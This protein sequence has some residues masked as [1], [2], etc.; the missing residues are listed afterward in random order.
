MS[1]IYC[2]LWC[3]DCKTSK[4]VKYRKSRIIPQ[5]PLSP[6]YMANKKKN[7]RKPGTALRSMYKLKNIGKRGIL[8]K[9]ALEHRCSSRRLISALQQ[10]QNSKYLLKPEW[11]FFS[12]W[13]Q[14]LLV[15]TSDVILMS[16]GSQFK[17]MATEH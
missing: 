6:F 7:H 3:C 11:V 17:S 4:H 1:V 8:N 5:I 13:L 9:Q 14:V 12:V 16:F 2:A 10:N 15:L